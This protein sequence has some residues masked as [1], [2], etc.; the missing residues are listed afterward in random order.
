MRHCE[1]GHLLGLFQSTRKGPKRRFVVQLKGYCLRHIGGC[2]CSTRESPWLCFRRF[3]P[4]LRSSIQLDRKHILLQSLSSI[5]GIRHNVSHS[6]VSVGAMPRSGKH[7]ST[8]ADGTESSGQPL[9]HNKNIQPSGFD[10]CS[11]ML[12]FSVR[13]GTGRD[14]WADSGSVEELRQGM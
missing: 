5:S 1:Q 3:C 9:H 10:I 7:K 8:A 4:S 13:I 14:H 12:R 6:S 2:P 11:E